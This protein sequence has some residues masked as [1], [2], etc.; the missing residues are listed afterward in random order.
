MGK[1][2]SAN[3]KL[4]LTILVLFKIIKTICL[5]DNDTICSVRHAFPAEYEKTIY[6]I[7]LTPFG[8]RPW[9]PNCPKCKLNF[10]Q[11]YC[12]VNNSVER[13]CLIR[14]AYLETDKSCLKKRG[15]K[16]ENWILTE[17]LECAYVEVCIFETANDF[18]FCDNNCTLE[19][20]D[21]I[22]CESKKAKIFITKCHR[23]FIHCPLDERCVFQDA[24][25]TNNLYR[26]I[27]SG[28]CQEHFE[29]HS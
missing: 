19:D 6:N 24:N 25:A 27:F 18:E 2:Y 12:A 7:S 20:F 21:K 5:G 8:Y 15:G 14:R 28:K 1:V 29:F 26:P 13:E 3:C 23:A 22:K 9:P 4:V 17:T 11:Q 10:H 16:R